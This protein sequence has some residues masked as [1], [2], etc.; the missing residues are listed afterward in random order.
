MMKAV[1]WHFMTNSQKV[2]I[3]FIT[4]QPFALLEIFLWFHGFIIG[5]AQSTQ[6][7]ACCSIM[8]T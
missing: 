4:M 8:E 6:A 3:E 5:H 2:K 7:W 1:V